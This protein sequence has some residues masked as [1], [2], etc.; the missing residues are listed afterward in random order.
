MR[1]VLNAEAV[2]RLHMAETRL[3]QLT[4]FLEGFAN[5]KPKDWPKD[6]NPRVDVLAAGLSHAYHM[7]GSILAEIKHI[8][9]VKQ[10]EEGT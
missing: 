6:K 5:P 3:E 8:A 4:R 10:E 9:R 1:H 7:A 2:S